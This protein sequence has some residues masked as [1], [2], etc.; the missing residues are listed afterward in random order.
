M[1]LI[2]RVAAASS[3]AVRLLRI[4]QL[5]STLIALYDHVCTIDIEVEYIWSK[6]WAS[7]K[8]LFLLTRYIGDLLLIFEWYTAF[9]LPS[10]SRN[11]GVA[12]DRIASWGNLLPLFLCQTTLCY[13]LSALYNNRKPFVI[14]ICF[15][16][17]L[18]I[19]GI[20]IVILYGQQ[21]L[22]TEVVVEFEGTYL[23]IKEIPVL[24]PYWLV[25]VVFETIL[26]SLTIWKFASNIRH[27]QGIRRVSLGR[28]I[29]VDGTMYY[30]MS[31]IWLLLYCKANTISG[32][33]FI[34]YL[35]VG[36]IWAIRPGVYRQISTCFFPTFSTTIG[37]K[38]I[39]HLS[40]AHANNVDSRRDVWSSEIFVTSLGTGSRREVDGLERSSV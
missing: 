29:V 27:I 33:S 35:A 28:L 36:L 26:F 19:L 7:S 1:S 22:P 30:I 6:P 38:L 24:S 18:E 9:L 16:F 12:I 34:L 3:H 31:V 32:R 11:V 10:V 21:K 4:M 8:I 25:I 14:S 20:S 40:E 2:A 15:I 39:L 37:Y 23:C 5:T 17:L 13:R